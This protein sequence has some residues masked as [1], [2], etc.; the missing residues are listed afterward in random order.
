M[1]ACV[2]TC[3]H[4]LFVPIGVNCSEVSGLG[5]GEQQRQRERER[6]RESAN[7][8]LHAD[9]SS[10][11]F[12]GIAVSRSPFVAFRCRIKGRVTRKTIPCRT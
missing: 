11:A 12:L 6:E 1:F 4:L 9:R 5:C 10:Q 3:F 8:I 7:P 2:L